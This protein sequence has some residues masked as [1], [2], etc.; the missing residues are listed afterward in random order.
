MIFLTDSWPHHCPNCG[1]QTG[2]VEINRED[3]KS[4]AASSCDVCG[5]RWQ[6]VP[7][8][9]LIALASKHGDMDDYAGRA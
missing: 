5:A 2:P 1:T 6:H 8:S 9:A 3:F 4:G 7:T